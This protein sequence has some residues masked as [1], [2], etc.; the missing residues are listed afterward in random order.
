M[1]I[2]NDGNEQIGI[3]EIN[4]YK[5]LF[6]QQLFPG[7][8]NIGLGTRLLQK[9]TRINLTTNKE[10]HEYF[11]KLGFIYETLPQYSKGLFD[12]KMTP[13]AWRLLDMLKIKFNKKN[14]KRVSLIYKK[15]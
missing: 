11:K 4:T 8:S 13:S 10:S 5:G 15:F 9:S 3:C 1:A 14:A 7:I 6:L 12:I 2:S